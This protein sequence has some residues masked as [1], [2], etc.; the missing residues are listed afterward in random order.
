M[1]KTLLLI[2]F[3]FTAIFCRA[4]LG[5]EQELEQR[6]IGK[7]KFIDIKAT[8]EDFYE[9]KTA[10][11][12]PA[13]SLAKKRMNRQRKFW[14][15]YLFDAESHLDSEG[16]IVNAARKSLDFINSNNLNSVNRTETSAGKWTLI[17]PTYVEEG[18]G[19]VNRIAFDP[20]STAIIYAGSSGGGLFKTTNAGNSWSNVSSFLPSLGIS[21]IVVVNSNTIYILTGD[22]DGQS[23]GGLTFKSGYIRYSVGILK[24]TDG[25]TTWQSTAPFP[26]IENEHYSGMQLVRDPNNPNI[27]LAATTKGLFRTNN[28]GDSWSLCNIGNSTT[29][30]DGVMI[31]DVKFAPGS[32][33]NVYCTIRN[34]NSSTDGVFLR[35]TNGGVSFPFSNTVTFASSFTE[36]ERIGIG[37]TPDNPSKVY[38][39]AGPGSPGG[40]SFKGLW[41]SSDNGENFTLQSNSP[42]VLGRLENNEYEEQNMYDLAIAISPSNEKV[43]V[44]GGL[45]IFKS[46]T[47]GILFTQETPYYGSESI[48]PDVHELVYNTANGKL[49]AGTDG[50]VAVSSNNGSTWTKLFS[51]LTCTQFYHFA[52]QDDGGDMWGGTQD[53]GILVRNGNASSFDMY[54]SGDGYD[55]LTDM[56]PAGN[57]DDKYYSI[58]EK[59]FADAIIDE[60]IT[61]PGSNNFFANLAMSP[62]DEDVIYAGYKKLFVSTNRGDDWTE[63]KTSTIPHRSI[64]GNWCISSCPTNNTKLY[65]AGKDGLW[66]IEG[67]NSPDPNTTTNLTDALIAAG[68]NDQQKITDIF[69]SENT[70]NRL[71]V[72]VGGYTSTAK[73][74]YSNNGG[75]SWT[76]KS[77]SLPNLPVNAVT[78]DNNDNIYIGTDIGVYYRGLNDTEWT[79]FYNGLPRVAVSAIEYYNGISSNN[80]IYVSTYGRGL[81]ASEAFS[82]CA[83]DMDINQNLTGQKFYQADNITSN[84]SIEGGVG[85][86]VFFRAATSVTLYPE[87]IVNS[88]TEF[89]AYIG[90]CNSGAAPYK[91][92]NGSDSIINVIRNI[93]SARQYGLVHSTIINGLAVKGVFNIFTKG[94]YSIRIFD[95]ETG[96]YLSILPVTFAVG[97]NN[98]DFTLQPEWGKYLRIDLFKSDMLV[99]YMDF[100]KK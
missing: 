75:S 22:G 58:N 57:Q 77:G 35:S 82:A 9:E 78:A 43:V 76:N 92:L 45:V 85:T 73:V 97:I 61:P 38:L 100:E 29:S 62:T 21:G 3:A 12:L 37:V 7:S 90:P 28:G 19:R 91:M 96:R 84:S 11:L 54:A 44:A 98:I 79:P 81:W 14:N 33:N 48:H 39:L 31:Y 51:G 93:K 4:Q 47:G 65:S 17:G 87:F 32:S 94:D 71:W 10:T 2:F 13:D 1:K 72:T 15:R 89:T 16:Y 83:S 55:V 95:T 53:N 59:I 20:S 80:I 70:S 68:Y 69:V 60:D 52:R 6:L 42:N 25:G 24:T 63:I 5:Q 66:L 86:D 27:L 88:G 26:G 74:F 64:G 40:N 34:G 23:S 8:V 49:Y 30:D 56:A 99:H 36:I 18:I 50:G 67:L 46:T 41:I